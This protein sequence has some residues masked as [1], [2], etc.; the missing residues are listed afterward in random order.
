MGNSHVVPGRGQ[1]TH[2]VPGQPNFV[3]Y[4]QN[5]HVIEILF[6]AKILW[7]RN[8]SPAD[9]RGRC[10]KSYRLVTFCS[11]LIPKKSGEGNNRMINRNWLTTPFPARTDLLLQGF[12]SL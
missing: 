11:L 5:A 12:R 1:G 2:N 10:G 7:C 6:T 9:S 8:F 3:F 4:D